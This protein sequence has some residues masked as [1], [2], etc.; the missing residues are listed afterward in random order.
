MISD[1][2]GPVLTLSWPDWDTSV[3]LWV[4]QHHSPVM[5]SFMVFATGKWEWIPL[6]LILMYIIYKQYR[7]KALIFI[8]LAALCVTLSDQVSV[9]LFKDMFQRLRPCHEPLL[10]GMVRTW[11]GR[12]GGSYGFISSHAANSFGIALLV[13]LA[14]K[15]YWLTISMLLWASLVSY[16]RV[17]LGVH[18]PLDIM[19][20]AVVGAGIGTA[21]FILSDR[22]IPALAS[23]PPQPE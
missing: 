17:Y 5:D 1:I 14:I 11:E 9:H 18:Y 4:N 19:A 8:V 23:R 21:V 7:M 13:I 10:S 22:F 6:Y 12:C 2:L 3:F 15:K 16:S 20:G